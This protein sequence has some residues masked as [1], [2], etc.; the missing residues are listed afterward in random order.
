VVAVAAEIDSTAREPVATAP[1]VL[2][3]TPVAAV[4]VRSLNAPDADAFP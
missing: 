3:A 1:D 4:S 2:D